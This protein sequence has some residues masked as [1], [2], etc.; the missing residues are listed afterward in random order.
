MT[1]TRSSLLLPSALV[2]A[3]ALTSIS[4]PAHAGV[5]ADYIPVQGTSL[6]GAELPGVPF[7]DLATVAGFLE[8]APIV[9]TLPDGISA[10]FVEFVGTRIRAFALAPKSTSTGQAG[11]LELTPE[12]LVGTEWSIPM[13]LNGRC[14]DIR[15]RIVDTALDGS[16][17]TMSAHGDNR[18][19]A[20][21][22]L[23]YTRTATPGRHDWL[24]PCAT[25][26]E[27]HAMG[28]FVSGRWRANGSYRAGGQ[29]FS[30]ARGV[31]AKCVR[32]W[33]YKP[34]RRLS[35]G[36]RSVSLLPLHLACIRAARADYCGD[37]VSHTVDGRV[38]D[39]FDRYGFNVR[40]P[41]LPGTPES[42][43]SVDRAVWL[44]HPRVPWERL[45]AHG[46]HARGQP[47]CVARL[48][49]IAD[50]PKDLLIRVWS[51]VDDS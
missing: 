25:A 6:Q 2:L 5:A 42:A 50:D 39:L 8:G 45:Y 21:F 34:W 51:L 43:F 1:C 49:S 35:T 29:T 31:I 47:A 14:E 20:L 7:Q 41:F 15:Y 18:D 19:V 40:S 38:V 10:V 26:T 22:E 16:R 37:G 17:N 36:G 23:H 28:L 46:V 44:R 9:A 13:C 27:P 32:Q 11:F 24:N 3:L 30:C 12:Q 4:L 33:G 48:S